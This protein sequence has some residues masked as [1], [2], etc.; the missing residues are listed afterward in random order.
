MRAEVEYDLLLG[1]RLILQPRI[2]AVAHG[3]EDASRGIGAG[4]SEAEAGLRLRYEIRREFAP[5]IGIERAHRFGKTAGFARAAGGE[6][7]E[8]RWVFGLRAWF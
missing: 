8:T 3:R 1:N 7:H 2:E 4:L 5:Y 6:A